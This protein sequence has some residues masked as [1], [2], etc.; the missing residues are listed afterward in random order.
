[1]YVQGSTFSFWVPEERSLHKMEAS[2]L[3]SGL[4]VTIGEHAAL[5]MSNALAKSCTPWRPEDSRS[6]S[7]ILTRGSG[8]VKFLRHYSVAKQGDPSASGGTW[9]AS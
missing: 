3:I 2:L 6:N 4:K 8:A 5:A 1:M 9:V 7:R